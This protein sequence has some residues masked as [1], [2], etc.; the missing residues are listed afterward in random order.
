MQLKTHEL[1]INPKF[2]K[3]IVVDTIAHKN[4]YDAQQVHRHNYYEILIFKKA[5]GG[6]Q[7]IDFNSFEIKESAYYMVHPGQIHLIKNLL[8]KEGISIQFTKEFITLNFTAQEQDWIQGLQGYSEV[9]C[10]KNR[11][12]TIAQLS[13]TLHAVFEEKS[14]YG[15]DKVLS[16]FR[17]LLIEFLESSTDSRK[18][19][20]GNSNSIGSHFVAMVQEHFREIRNVQDYAKR[21]HMSP[22]KLN[23]SLK[24]G[25]GKSAK[26]IIQAQL[27]LEIKRLLLVGE[28]THKEIFIHLNFDSQNSY[29]RFIDKQT[30]LTP[31]KL[32]DQLIQ[33]HK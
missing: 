12:H 10:S 18:E 22:Q 26:D 1:D 23:A 32:K 27:L 20:K 21:M 28:L 24:K 5:N 19:M 6:T 31:T 8:V 14:Q 17:L 30:G 3:G 7:I 11:F 13:E 29:N 2:H 25:L 9:L 15:F 33:N 16:Y 4:P